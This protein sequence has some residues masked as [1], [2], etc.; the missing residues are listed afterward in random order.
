MHEDD[1]CR[2]P[3]HCLPGNVFRCWCD[4]E[5][6]ADVTSK[7]CGIACDGDSEHG[8]VCGGDPM[9]DACVRTRIAR[10]QDF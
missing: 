9:C 4:K 5:P 10:K 3:V 7:H 1:H 6:G 8:D 2:F